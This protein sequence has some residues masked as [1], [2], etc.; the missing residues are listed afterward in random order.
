MI[1]SS[2][3]KQAPTKQPCWFIERTLLV[4]AEEHGYFCSPEVVSDSWF[5]RRLERR[6]SLVFFPEIGNF[7]TKIEP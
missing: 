4:R 6:R 7:C 1:E 2:K 3:G 5:R